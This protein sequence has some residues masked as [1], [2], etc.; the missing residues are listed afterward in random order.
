M[1]ALQ[2]ARLCNNC[3]GHP[4]DRTAKSEPISTV[5]VPADTLFTGRQIVDLIND[6]L[7][8]GKRLTGSVAFSTY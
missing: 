2:P 5:Q 8:D 4:G 6:A 3:P 7:G 1:A